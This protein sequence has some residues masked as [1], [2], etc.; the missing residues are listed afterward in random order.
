MK[1]RGEGGECPRCLIGRGALVVYS[2][3]D[4]LDCALTERAQ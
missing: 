1:N 3:D 4:P 2:A